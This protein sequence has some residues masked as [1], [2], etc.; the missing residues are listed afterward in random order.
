MSKVVGAGLVSQS[1]DQRYELTDIGRAL[2]AALEPLNQWS[3]QWARH[4]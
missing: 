2:G 4:G 1:A 3:R